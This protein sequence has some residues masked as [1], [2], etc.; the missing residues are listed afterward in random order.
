M[1]SLDLLD[2]GCGRLVNGRLRIWNRREI[3]RRT[4][5]WVLLLL[6]DLSEG[7]TLLL[8]AECIEVVEDCAFNVC[9]FIE[10]KITILVLFIEHFI[11]IQKRC[12]IFQINMNLLR[13]PRLAVDSLIKFVEAAIELVT[14][15]LRLNIIEWPVVVLV[16]I[17][18]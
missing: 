12:I 4:L 17:L 9:G 18:F 7:D 5:E 15:V 11:D 3:L 16:L 13:H 10:I 8:V 14:V 6:F 1:I 2:R